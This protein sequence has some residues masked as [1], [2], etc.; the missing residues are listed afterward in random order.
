MSVID[1][2]TIIVKFVGAVVVFI[3]GMKLTSEGLQKV[4]GDKMSSIFGKMTGNPICVIVAGAAVAAAIQ[5]TLCL[6]WDII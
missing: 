1:I 3:Y 5:Q 2:I 6:V 4:A